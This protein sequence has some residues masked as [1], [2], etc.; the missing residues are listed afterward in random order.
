MTAYNSEKFIRESIDS[1]LS[2]T[3]TNLQFI[4]INDGSTDKSEQIIK[5]YNDPR[6]YYIKN[7][8]NKGIV[9]SLNKGLSL[10]NTKYICLLYTSRCV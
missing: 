5:E 8:C 7:S 9:Y 6:I 2:Q 4:I 1:V 3:Y 10:A